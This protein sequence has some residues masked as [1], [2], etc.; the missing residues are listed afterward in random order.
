[1]EHGPFGQD[2]N[3][4]RCSHVPYSCSAALFEEKG[5]RKRQKWPRNDV[6]MAFEV[7][8]SSFPW[9]PLHSGGETKWKMR[10][11]PQRSSHVVWNILYLFVF[12]ALWNRTK[13]VF[14]TCSIYWTWSYLTKRIGRGFQFSI[15]ASILISIFRSNPTVCTVHSAG[16]LQCI[17]IRNT[18]GT[19]SLWFLLFKKGWLSSTL[20]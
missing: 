7:S 4:S 10:K 19:H 15:A 18:K 12:M 13:C 2:F 1:M 11:N 14:F 6:E 8:L 16:F 3:P 17:E 20:T 9:H 5:W